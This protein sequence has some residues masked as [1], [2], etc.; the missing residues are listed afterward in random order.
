M[1]KAIVLCAA[2]ILLSGAAAAQ[3]WDPALF[4]VTP[5]KDCYVVCPAGDLWFCFCI[6]YDGEP[7]MAPTSDVWMSI[8]C[9]TGDFHLCPAECLDK[10]AGLV[11]EDCHSMPGCG[12]EY[13]WFYRLGG[14]CEQAT[15][16][17]HMKYDPTPFYTLVVPVKSTD[18]DGDGVVDAA[19]ESLLASMM[20]TSD[21]C[22]DLNCDGTVDAVDMAILLSHAGHGCEQWIGTEDAT[23]G[24]IKSTY[25]E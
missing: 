9:G 18:L 14:C 7:L 24:R 16:T 20:G 10:C 25:T 6:K 8:D 2:A 3:T 4:T 23:W 15:I 1:K 13:C 11:S 5:E 21:A 19:D 17:M 22:A 12:R